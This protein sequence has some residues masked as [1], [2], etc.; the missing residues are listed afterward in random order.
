MAVNELLVYDK[1][2]FDFFRV[3]D[4]ENNKLIGSVFAPP[5][6]AFAALKDLY[7]ID[8]KESNDRVPLP[9]T[10]CHRGDPMFDPTMYRFTDRW[11]A[12]Y[13]KP[14]RHDK[15]KVMGP[16]QS[17][18]LEYSLEVWTNTQV[19]KLNI[20]KQ[21][22]MK[23]RGELAY[24]VVDLQEYGKKRFSIRNGG[25]QDASVLEPQEEER[26]LRST[27][28][29]TLNAVLHQPLETRETVLTVEQQTRDME[30]DELLATSEVSDEDA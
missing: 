1:A 29:V 5:Q 24:I 26:T 30:T 19:E 13:D 21:L 12:R 27:M 15:V 18:T 11:I 23:F 6:K 10:A 8:E 7:E 16:P 25:I 4:D 17:I 2:M 14:P 9:A 22:S 28:N 20:L 3:T